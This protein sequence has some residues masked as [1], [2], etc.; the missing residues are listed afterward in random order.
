MNQESDE[1]NKQKDEYQILF[2]QAPCYITV[3]DKNLR[4]LRYNR[5]FA[6]KFTP[7]RGDFCYQA[8]KGRSQRCEACPV[9]KTFEDGKPHSSEETG[10]SKDGT[11]SYWVVRSAPRRDRDEP[12]CHPA[13]V[14]GTGG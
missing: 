2:E 14:L 8:Y 1:L 3:Q 12:R 10:V 5:E 13:E 9:L 11:T 4:L 6:E 7:E